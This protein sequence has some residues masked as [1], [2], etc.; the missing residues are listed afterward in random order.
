MVALRQLDRG[1]PTPTND[2]RK[3]KNGGALGAEQSMEVGYKG[4]F[5]SPLRKGLGKGSAKV[6]LFWVSKCVFWCLQLSQAN[7][8]LPTELFT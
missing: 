3:R 8:F 6:L 1:A 4:V 2:G 5:P 7:S